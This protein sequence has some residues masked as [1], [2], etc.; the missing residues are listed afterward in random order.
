MVHALGK[1]VAAHGVLPL[2]GIIPDMKSDT[3]SFIK[4]QM[5]YIHSNHWYRKKAV[6]DQAYF[7]TLVNASLISLGKEPDI[8]STEVINRFCKNAAFIQVLDFK[9]ISHELKSPVSEDLSMRNLIKKM[10]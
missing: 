1:F 2:A 3:E 8:I 4:L 10:N 6:D 9:S 5:M 7:M